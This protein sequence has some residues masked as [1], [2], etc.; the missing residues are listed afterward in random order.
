MTRA[1]AQAKHSEH[2]ANG[3][4]FSKWTNDRAKTILSMLYEKRTMLRELYTI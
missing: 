2:M 3:Q 1:L 4:S